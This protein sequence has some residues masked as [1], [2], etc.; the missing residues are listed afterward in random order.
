MKHQ[1]LFFAKALCCLF[2]AGL[3]VPGL[4]ADD[5]KD[6]QESK[7]TIDST[8]GDLLDNPKSLAILDRDAPGLSTDPQIGL[9]R[10]MS[11]RSV[12]PLSGGKITDEM[13]QVIEADLQKVN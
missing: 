10:F 11:L 12:A 3:L 4:A 1:K 9:G 7:L 8:I 13:L 5:S 2:L 6:S